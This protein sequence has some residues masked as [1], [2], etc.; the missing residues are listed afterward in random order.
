MEA[1]LQ[2]KADPLVEQKDG[3]SPLD[4]A[5]EF[6]RLRVVERLLGSCQTL[7]L[8]DG[9]SRT[10][11]RLHSPLHSAAKNGHSDVARY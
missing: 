3:K 8:I 11:Q 1:L 2:Y 4:F 9:Q 5:A 6:G 7:L 10:R